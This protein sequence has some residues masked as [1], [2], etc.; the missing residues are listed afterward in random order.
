MQRSD[1]RFQNT[2]WH[3]ALCPQGAQEGAPRIAN[4]LAPFA[5]ILR[6]QNPIFWPAPGLCSSI[7]GRQ[8]A[9]L[10]G[11][12]CHNQLRYQGAFAIIS[13]TQPC[14]RCPSGHTCSAESSSS[15]PSKQ[16]L[17]GGGRG[18]STLTWP[19]PSAGTLGHLAT[20]PS[21]LGLSFLG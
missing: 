21:P 13:P 17:A 3:L 6:R 16:T 9:E 11:S 20:V 18:P 19:W 15:D 10:P 12:I 1:A 8:Q 7:P 5:L 2:G 14:H 4:A